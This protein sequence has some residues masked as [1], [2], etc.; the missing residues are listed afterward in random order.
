MTAA[1]AGPAG[2]AGGW[3][4]AHVRALRPGR[5]QAAAASTPHRLHRMLIVIVAATAVWLLVAIVVVLARRDAAHSVRTQTAPALLDA[6]EAH[7]V[8]SDADRAVWASFRSGEAQL[9]GPGQGYQSDITTAGQSLEQIAALEPSGGAVSRQ[10]QAV[11]GLLVNYEGLVEQADATYRTGGAGTRLGYA[12]L[13]YASRSLHDKQGGLLAGIDKLAA[14]SRK[15]LSNSESSA[16]TS[17]LLLLS[18]AAAALLLLGSLLYAQAFL[19][20]RFRRTISPLLVVASAVVVGLSVWVGAVTLRGDH[21]F[22]TTQDAALSRLTAIWQTQTDDVDRQEKALLRNVAANGSVAGAATPA[23]SIAATQ[24][25]QAELDSAMASAT[26]TGGLIVALPMAAV[27][28]AGLAFLG[29]KRRLDEYR[30]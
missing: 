6:L 22:R 15:A 23:I 26:D 25:A 2:K 16:W 11:E 7:A 30:G 28:I 21:A 20:R 19:Q 9:I 14:N 1:A 29:F 17:P 5:R 18:Y 8:M 4:R 13:T 27:A 24:P 3:A 10:L 12:Y